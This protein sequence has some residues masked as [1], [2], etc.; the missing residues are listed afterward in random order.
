[1]SHLSEDGSYG[2]KRQARGP[3]ARAFSLTRC[4]A[5]FF[6]ELIQMRRDRMTFAMM[7]A[8]PVIQLMLFGYA[9]NTDPRHLPTVIE[10]RQSGPLSRSLIAGLRASSYFDI[11]ATV[12]GEGAA[13]AALRRGEA[14][15]AIVIPDRFE[16]AL[17]RGERPQILMMADASDPTVAGGATAAVN[18]IL[19][20]ALAEDLT[21]PLAGLAGAPP[22]YDLLIHRLYN[23]EAITAYNIVPGLL[24]VILT[25]TLTMATAIALTRE[26]ERGTMETLLAT[27]ASAV[28]IMLGKISPY[29]LLGLVQV[30]IVLAAAYGLFNVPFRGEVPFLAAGIAI[31]IV[32]NLM[33]GYLISTLARSQMQALQMTFFI[34]LPSMLLSGFMFP[35]MAMPDWARFIGEGLPLTHFLRIVRGVMLKGAGVADLSSEL[36]ALTGIL[37]VIGTL[38]LWRFRRTLD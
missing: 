30:A 36:W 29:V 14:A 12:T 9:I 8:I 22:A 34:F 24:G 2:P 15:F 38:A 21:G 10:V 23:P 32:T 28:E 7:V 33:L 27:P 6:K 17:V 5:V 37:G 1:M 26:R 13:E 25:M 11:R 35:F 3:Q 20:R 19:Q 4:L 18:T 16:Q 31:F